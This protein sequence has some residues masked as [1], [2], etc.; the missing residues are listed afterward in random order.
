MHVAKKFESN[1]RVAWEEEDKDVMVEK[2][3]GWI[4]ADYQV[5]SSQNHYLKKK[6]LMDRRTDGLT[7]GQTDGLTNGWMDGRTD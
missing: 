5:S 2:R 3:R 4:W 1:I 6:L 7:D